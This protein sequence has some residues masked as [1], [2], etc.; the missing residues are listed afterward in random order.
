MKVLSVKY[1][2]PSKVVTNEDLLRE[3]G[4][5]LLGQ[6]DQ[7]MRAEILKNLG[8]TLEYVGARTRYH[9]DTGERAV[10]FGIEAGRQALAAAGLE[11]GDIDLLIFVG[12][13]RGF[14]EPATANIFQSGLGC[15]RATCFDVLD[16]CASWL[17]GVDV[18]GHYL[19]CGT[20]RH[21]LIINCEFNF[22]E[23]ANWDLKSQEDLETAW[24]VYTIGE[25]ATATVLGASDEDDTFHTR[26]R[27]VG[28]D[29]CHC[30][31]PLPNFDQFHLVESDKNYPVLKFYS[32]A[33]RLTKRAVGML[34][35]QYNEDPGFKDV[36]HDI[37]FTHSASTRVSVSGIRSID[38]DTNRFHDVFPR[39]GNTVSATLPLGMADAIDKGVLERGQRVLMLMGSAGVTAGITTFIY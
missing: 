21:I 3:L 7:D 36:D 15:H 14:I 12:V 4:E 22:R 13:G 18:A 30:H 34:A 2:V 29:Y 10:D 26:F 1:A 27:T 33:A 17:R 35:D 9:R 37:I 24:S 38:L 6:A 31:I 11:P 19:R 25:A 23:Y 5:R 16:A 8:K 20:F 39:F 28:E 32:D